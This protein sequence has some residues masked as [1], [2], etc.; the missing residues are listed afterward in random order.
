MELDATMFK[1]ALDLA[2]VGSLK[3][4]TSTTSSTF[5]R[6]TLTPIISSILSPQPMYPSIFS[7]V[8]QIPARKVKKLQGIACLCASYLCSY[9]TC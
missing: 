3:V 9:F 2:C 1:L 5:Y 6:Q 7:V 4:S 8:S